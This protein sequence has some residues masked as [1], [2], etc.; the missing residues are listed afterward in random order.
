MRTLIALMLGAAVLAA[1]PAR[2]E[3]KVLACEP[4]WAALVRELA[5][6]KAS[7]ASATTA[8]QDPHRIEARPSLIA[9]ARNADLLVCTGADLEVGWLPVL[10]RES[11]NA[12]IQ[13]GTPGHF[14]AAA[15]VPLLDRPAR[16]DRSM[17]DVHAAGNPHLHLDPRNI[18]RVADA[19]AVRLAQVDKGNAA[20]YAARNRD[21]QLRWQ[22]ALERWQAR[23]APL[24][25][26]PLAVHHKDW[27]YLAHWLGMGVAATLEPKPGVEPSVAHLGRVLE[28]LR[29]QPAR[30]V[31]HTHYQSPRAARWLAERAGVPVVE[32]PYTVGSAPGTD[33]LFAWMDVLLER[34]L[35]AVK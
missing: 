15:H 19:L 30:L 27:V 16:V 7:V 31:V 21:F 17:G 20:H 26:M 35:G 23:A 4:E 13:P 24:K 2:A 14:E 28:Q 8:F 9:R 5:G 11:G 6:D 12:R 18:A 34:L 22:D 25:G 10:Q 1:T 32:L 33:T 29:Q 3:L